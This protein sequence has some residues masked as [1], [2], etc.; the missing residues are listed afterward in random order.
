MPPRPIAH[1]IVVLFI[2]RE[3][4]EIRRIPRDMVETIVNNFYVRVAAMIQQR[5]AWIEHVI[6]Y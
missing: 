3:I 4:R 1:H 6:N 2:L 5:A